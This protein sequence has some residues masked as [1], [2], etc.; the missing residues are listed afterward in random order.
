MQVHSLFT[1]PVKS[2]QGISHQVITVEPRGLLRDRRW[3]VV[4]AVQNNKAL[5]QRSHGRLAQIT[6]S[7]NAAGELVLA[8][9]EQTNLTVPASFHDEHYITVWDDTV[10]AY[11]MGNA[12][13]AWLQTVLQDTAIQ[14]RLYYQGDQHFRPVDPA[15]GQPDDA[16]SFADG[17]PLL[18]TSAESL[19]DLN[20]RMQQPAPME[21]FRPNI[22]IAGFAPYAE[23]FFTQIRIGDVVFDVVNGCERCKIVTLEQETGLP[24]PMENNPLKTLADYRRGAKNKTYF[25]VD[26]IPRTTGIIRQGDAVEVLSRQDVAHH[27]KAA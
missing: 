4:N 10:S 1:Y 19:D 13:A 25:G 8:H 5:T 21:R 11:D 18:L 26:L 24:G 9:N 17:S 6:P 16:V 27:L 23:D 20:Q 22:V 2:C 7:F 12:A 14:P 3:V 15:Y